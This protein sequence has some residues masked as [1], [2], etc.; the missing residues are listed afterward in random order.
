MLQNKVILKMLT[1]YSQET[2]PTESIFSKL[3][4]HF[5][6]HTNPRARVSECRNFF[7]YFNDF[8]TDSVPTTEKVFEI[9]TGNTCDGVGFQYCYGW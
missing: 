7:C 2:T 5:S 6:K 3:K 4:S 9:L 8:T 1:R